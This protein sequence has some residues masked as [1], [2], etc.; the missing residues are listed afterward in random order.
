[1]ATEFKIFID[2]DA[3]DVFE[4]ISNNILETQKIVSEEVKKLVDDN[5][6]EEEILEEI[7]KKLLKSASDKCKKI[8]GDFS[9]HI[10]NETQRLLS[11]GITFKEI[12][13]SYLIYLSGLS[14][15][16][17]MDSNIDQALRLLAMLNSSLGEYQSITCRRTDFDTKFKDNSQGNFK[18]DTLLK[19][20]YGMAN[21]AFK[22]SAHDTRKQSI[23]IQNTLKKIEINIDNEE[24]FKFLSESKDLKKS[25]LEKDYRNKG[26]VTEKERES[27]L[28]IILGIAIDKFAYDPKAERNTATGNNVGIG[29]RIEFE[30]H[31]DTVR[32]CLDAAIKILDAIRSQ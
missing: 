32:S 7:Y 10:N 2:R 24:I 3:K 8:G 31:N 26:S 12:H 4:S 28:L 29:I 22:T 14:A 17:L 9:L 13:L 23:Y 15:G 30:V 20:I 6:H 5:S 16:Y 1:M 19:L 25:W 18:R 27:M 21:H 11:S